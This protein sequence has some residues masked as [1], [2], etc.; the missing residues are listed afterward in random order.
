[1]VLIYDME[2]LYG[3]ALIAM[4]AVPSAYADYLNLE[5][6]VLSGDMA[7]FNARLVL[8]F[9]ENDIQELYSKS[10]TTPTLEYGIIK[11]FDKIYT[12]DNAR[13]NVMGQSFTLKAFE[14]DYTIIIYA[15]NL[16]NDTFEV[17]TYIYDDNRIKITFNSVLT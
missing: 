17:R 8:G 7:D 3:L 11:I 5:N 14:N 6:T 2:L 12:I 1:V 15:Q 13:V 4:L 9:G 16:G 10:L